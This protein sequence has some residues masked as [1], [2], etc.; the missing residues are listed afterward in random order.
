MSEEY[1]NLLP[2]T[3]PL[4]EAPPQE[5][6]RYIKLDRW[7]GYP[8]AEDALAQLEELFDHPQRTRMPSR[9]LVGATNNGKSML[10]AKFARMHGV[11]PGKTSA[12]PTMQ[13]PV[14]YVQ[15]PSG[16]DEKLFF[17]AVFKVLGMPERLNERMLA[18]QQC[19]AMRLIEAAKVRV[20]A[21]DEI[22]NLLAGNRTQQ[23]R[24]LN[25]IRWM[26]N[27]LN[28]PLVAGGTV[29]GLRAVQSDDQLANRFTP[30]VLPLWHMGPE[31]LRL[32]NT[33]EA[34]LPLRRASG[35]S[36]PQFAQRILTMAEG[37]LG[38]IV[39]TVTRAAVHAIA[40]GEEI[41]SART[42]DEI[43]WVPPSERRRA[44]ERALQR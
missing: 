2:T 16:P 12:V 13:V 5:R 25:L 15:M 10:L 4:A 44:A 22:H 17:A 34:V 27:E 14:L 21:I 36:K 37:A 39:E 35:L 28:I 3:R 8:R 29:E 18:R 24:F 6:V 26:G 23:R 31:Y 40:S 11:A 20:M 1:P 30:V 9:I 38:E 33:L 41:I 7:I 42:L 32:L 43:H 19:A